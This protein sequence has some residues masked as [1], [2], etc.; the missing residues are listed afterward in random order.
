MKQGMTVKERI[1]RSS[2]DLF[3]E[4]GFE[5]TTLNDIIDAAQISKGTFYYYFR[6]KNTLLNTL[7]VLL[8]DEY[9]ELEEQL[10]DDMSAFDKLMFLNDKVH[11][12]IGEKI[13]FK[14]MAN[15][16]SSHLLNHEESNL[17]DKNRYYYQLTYRIVV[18]GQRK[19]ELIN[20]MTAAEIVN[21]YSMCERALVTEWCMSDGNIDLGEVSRIYMPMLFAAFKAQP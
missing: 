7:S 13:S 3:Y 14:L 4:K 21:A 1:I 18:D 10:T 5:D 17:L 2:W 19:G 9:M 20:T 8:D 11:T 15:Q 6:S 16:Y 12:Y